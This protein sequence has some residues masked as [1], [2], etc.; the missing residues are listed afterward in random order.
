MPVDFSPGIMDDEQVLHRRSPLRPTG[1]CPLATSAKGLVGHP[2]AVLKP[3]AHKLWVAEAGGRTTKRQPPPPPLRKP[4]EK[5][6][7]RRQPSARWNCGGNA[8]CRRLGTVGVRTPY[9]PPKHG[10]RPVPRFGIC[11]SPGWQSRG[12]HIRFFEHTV[13]SHRD[14]GNHVRLARHSGLAV[15][16]CAGSVAAAK[17]T[18][19]GNDPAAGSPDGKVWL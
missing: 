8:R 4:A 9:P 18:S 11:R 1:W 3:S 15:C 5:T 19:A 10:K 12:E 17:Q 14:I 13:I 7:P 16:G 6:N 2:A